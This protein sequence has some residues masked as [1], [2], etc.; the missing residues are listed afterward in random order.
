MFTYKSTLNPKS[1][2]TRSIESGASTHVRY[3]HHN[4]V[5][6][7]H[8]KCS[9]CQKRAV[10]RLQQADGEPY[11]SLFFG[12]ELK[13]KDH[14][15]F[16]A[17]EYC[18][19]RKTSEDLSSHVNPFKN[20]GEFYYKIPKYN[21]WAYNFDH[22][23]ASYAYLQSRRDTQNIYNFILRAYFRREWLLHK[24]QL[25]KEVEKKYFPTS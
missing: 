5:T 7:L 23:L 14:K 2:N 13:R 24:K 1:A 10:A 22:F 20:V 9:K 17:C 6:F 3:C 21:F 4:W 15:W 19:F 8:V 18:V 25:I 16:I 12:D 11:S